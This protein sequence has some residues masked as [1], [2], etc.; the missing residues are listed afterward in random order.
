[1]VPGIEH[2]AQVEGPVHIDVALQRMRE[3]WAIGRVGPQIRATI[4]AAITHAHVAW[5]GQFIDRPDGS[6]ATVRYPAEGVARKAEHIADTELKLAMVNRVRE[7][8][9]HPVSL[10]V[11]KG[12]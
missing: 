10:V 4:E 5:D 1:M 2:L 9:T 3:A 6:P 7:G 12:H 11:E 8:G